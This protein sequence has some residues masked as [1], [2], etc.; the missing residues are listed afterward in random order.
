M[1]QDLNHSD[2]APVVQ[3]KIANEGYIPHINETP[4][5][6]LIYLKIAENDTVALKEH[7]QKLLGALYMSED[8]TGNE[9][10]FLNRFKNYL[11][12]LISY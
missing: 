9:R 3:W 11:E 7:Y 8:L 10:M 6:A 2:Y 12:Q 1:Q 5:E 4:Q